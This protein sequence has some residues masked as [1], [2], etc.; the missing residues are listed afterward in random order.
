MTGETET[1]AGTGKKTPS[2]ICSKQPLGV[3]EWDTSD[4]EFDRQLLEKFLIGAHLH[5]SNI[6]YDLINENGK[7]LKENAENDIAKLRTR[8]S[9]RTLTKQDKQNTERAP[10]IFLKD[11]FE[12]PQTTI[13]T[14][15]GHKLEQI[16]HKTGRIARKI[17]KPGFF[18]AQFKILEN[19][20]IVNSLPRTAWVWENGKQPWVMG[21]K[22]L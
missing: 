17:K 10:L 21:N 1:T 20:S 14:Q 3:N 8:K 9:I 6:Q 12:G 13:N 15:L 18:G 7:F 4:N 22:T 19:G 2:A 11:R 5:L 16:A